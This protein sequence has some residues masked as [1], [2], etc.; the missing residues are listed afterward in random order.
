MELLGAN[1]FNKPERR[2]S[3]TNYCGNT[4]VRSVG[5]SVSESQAM[6]LSAVYACVDVISNDVA[7]L[8][9]EPYYIDSKGRKSKAYLDPS[10]ELLCFEPSPH[11]TRYT[12]MQTLVASML[13]KGEAFAEIVR[14]PNGTAQ[15]I[16]VIPCSDVTVILRQPLGVIDC[17]YI[18]REDRYI[19][20]ENMIHLLNFTYDG[21]RGVSTLMHAARTL[22]I[23]TASEMHAEDFFTSGAKMIGI[24]KMDNLKLKES[25]KKDIR[26][27][28]QNNFNSGGHTPAILSG[29]ATFT[30]ISISPKESQLLESRQFNLPEICRFFRVSPTKI[31]DL[32]NLSYSTLEATN[33]AHVTDTISSYLEKIE[34]EIRR[35]VFPKGVRER[36]RVEFDTSVLVRGDIAA[37]TDMITRMI[38]AGVMTI[39]EARSKVNLPPVDGG[40]EPMMMVNIGTLANAKIPKAS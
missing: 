14:L 30:P 7:K 8:P 39:N 37:T 34:Q 38:P 40:D 4:T 29:N 35:K 17:Y 12:M 33:L 10:Y 24:I 20:V 6:K 21:I 9:L 22:R 18:G 3:S 27:E 28:W 1:L 2:A 11:M 32:S 19:E 31:Y 16:R 36:I 23:A 26:D 13:L 15:Q 5:S 25:E